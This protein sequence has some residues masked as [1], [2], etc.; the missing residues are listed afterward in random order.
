MT[1]FS[2]VQ[3]LDAIQDLKYVGAQKSFFKPIEVWNQ[4]FQW[5]S[6][7]ML[8]NDAATCRSHFYFMVID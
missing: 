8:S 3:E 2:T 6:W 5:A 1:H 7:L 4:A